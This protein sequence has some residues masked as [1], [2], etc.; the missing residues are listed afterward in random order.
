MKKIIASAWKDTLLR[1]TGWSE[2]IFFLILPIVFTLVLAGGTGGSKDNRV[3]LVVVDQANSP[4]SAD[5]V[6]ALSNSQAVR[7]DLLTIAQA[8]A[9]FSQRTAS[10]VLIIPAEF[11][12]AHLEQGTIQLELR[13]Q[14]NNMNASVA[15]RAVQSVISR[16]SSA[17][18]I[19][20]SSVTKAEQILSL[21][22]I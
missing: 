9:Q 13:Q 6:A 14:P 8:E 18:D 4:L 12:L 11:D 20:N 1:F 22:H 21:I 16:V 19:A 10:A 15:Q 2:W 7:P 3:R 17:A 5:L